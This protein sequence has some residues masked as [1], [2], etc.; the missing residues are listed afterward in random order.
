MHVTLHNSTRRLKYTIVII[1]ENYKL[2][3]TKYLLID[4]T[5]I[6]IAIQKANVS[7]ICV[8]N[9]ATCW[10]SLRHAKFDQN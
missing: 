1:L 7:R 10:R 9:V 5:G 3:N 6:Q 4:P 8:N 2:I